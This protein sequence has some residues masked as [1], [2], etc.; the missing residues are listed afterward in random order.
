MAA[1]GPSV[2]HIALP[3]ILV[4]IERG[5]L[6]LADSC[7]RSAHDEISTE[8]FNR[9]VVRGHRTTLSSF[10][11]HIVDTSRDNGGL[12]NS[13]V[14][15]SEG[16]RN[17][18]V[19]MQCG[20]IVQTE[21][22]VARNGNRARGRIHRDSHRSRSLGGDTT[23]NADSLSGEGVITSF[24]EVDGKDIL[25]LTRNLNTVLIP[26]ITGNL[27]INRSSESNLLTLADGID[28]SRNIEGGGQLV[29]DN[30]NL[31][32]SSA[33][34]SS[35]V[36][37]GN[38]S[39]HMISSRA[40]GLD[41]NRGSRAV[42]SLSIPLISHIALPTILIDIQRGVFA[43]ADAGSGS[44]HKEVGTEGLNREGFRG[45]LTTK[46]LN[47][48]RVS[49]GRN[50][51]SIL[52]RTS[53]PSDVARNVA[54]N[55]Q[56][57]AVVLAN[58]IVTADRN[59]SRCRHDR[60]RS[61]SR[62]QGDTTGD[63]ESHNSRVA[64]NRDVVVSGE[65]VLAEGSASDTDDFLTVSVPS[66]DSAIGRSAMS[67]DRSGDRNLSAIANSVI[68]DENSRDLRN[69]VHRDGDFVIVIT[70]GVGLVNNNTVSGRDVRIHSVGRHGGT[71]DEV[72][73]LN[74]IGFINVGVILIVTNSGGHIVLSNLIPL[75]GKIVHVVVLQVGSQS[76]LAIGADQSLGSGDSH[77]RLRIDVHIELVRHGSASSRDVV[78]LNIDREDV[79][80]VA[81][82][83]VFSI[84][85]AVAKTVGIIV[86]DLTRLIPSVVEVTDGESGGIDI[87]NQEHRVSLTD[88]L[89]ASDHNNRIRIHIDGSR[90]GGLE[91]RGTTGLRESHNSSVSVVLDIIVNRG[92]IVKDGSGSSIRHHD[93][94]AIPSVDSTIGRHTVSVNRG[95][96]SNLST[97]TDIDVGNR[98][99]G[100]NR[101]RIHRDGERDRLS[102]TTRSELVDLDIVFM[103]TNSRNFSVSQRSSTRDILAITIPLEGEL[104]SIPIVE[105]QSHGDVTTNTDVGL[106]NGGVNDR[107]GIDV[108]LSLAGSRAC[109]VI[110]NLDRE[111]VRIISI[112]LV[113]RNLIVGNNRV[114]TSSQSSIIFHPIEGHVRTNIGGIHIGS[115]RNVVAFLN[116]DDRIGHENH[117]RIRV[118]RD[119]LESII[120][121]G[122]TTRSSLSDRHCIVISSRLTIQSADNFAVSRS[123]STLNNLTVTI[124]SEDLTAGDTASDR[125]RQINLITVT[126]SVLSSSVVQNN[127][128]IVIHDNSNSIGSGVTER[129]QLIDLNRVLMDTRSRNNRV[130]QL[131]GISNSCVAIVPTIGQLTSIPVSEVSREGNLTTVTN[132]SIGSSNGHNRLSVD[133]DKSASLGDASVVVDELD[134]EAVRIVSVILM[135][136][137]R[138]SLRDGDNIVVLHPLIGNRSKNL[139][140]DIGEQR[141][142]VA[143][144]VTNDRIGDKF[145]NRIRVDR[146]VIKLIINQRL[147][148][149][150]TLFHRNSIVVKGGFAINSDRIVSKDALVE[151]LNDLTI[152]V[153]SVNFTAFN[154]TIDNASHNSN[155]LTLT[156]SGLI[157]SD[158]HSLNNRNRVHINTDGVVSNAILSVE[159]H[160]MRNLN[161]VVG[162][163]ENRLKGLNLVGGTGEDMRVVHFILIPLVGQHR[164]IVVIEVGAQ[165]NITAFANLSSV[166]RDVGVRSLINIHIERIGKGGTTIAIGHQDSEDVG[167]LIGGHPRLAIV[168][169]ETR[170]IGS[171]L[172]ALIPSISSIEVNNT[173]NPSSKND[174]LNART[175]VTNVRVTVNRNDRVAF[176]MNRVRSNGNRLTTRNVINDIGF[177]SVI[178]RITIIDVGLCAELRTMDGLELHAI[179]LP[180]IV[181]IIVD[182]F[183]TIR[184]NHVS[185]NIQLG[186]FANIIGNEVNVVIDSNNTGNLIG[187]DDRHRHRITVSITTGGRLLNTDSVHN[188]TGDTVKERT[189]DMV[190]NTGGTVINVVPSHTI[191]TVLPLSN[192]VIHIPVAKVSCSGNLTLS[193]NFS[194]VNRGNNN[195]IFTHIDIVRFALHA[196]AFRSGH[197]K[198]KDIR[199]I[200][201]R[202]RGRDESIITRSH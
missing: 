129:S 63:R 28:I 43:A 148:T 197:D 77:N 196:A 202:K 112:G 139:G 192:Q 76:N 37:G 5:V 23:L 109:V 38:Y 3:T 179:Q 90:S 47:R 107:V 16:T 190:Q 158:E 69:R 117:N 162:S 54:V 87:R 39:R 167:V 134:A 100:D 155:G 121:V 173:I 161:N 46:S 146:N 78:T 154:T 131:R 188:I 94:I 65:D 120:D 12:A 1:G 149:R 104:I 105:I 96:N 200:L 62:H 25:V 141:D 124:P 125:G 58:H 143:S 153:P 2:G 36:R 30:G 103:F 82:I 29:D 75:I 183:I 64:V 66:I 198:S 201:C 142:V 32:L 89:I 14:A 163:T 80:F 71:G 42:A 133:I 150:S 102:L 55:S 7:S 130:A 123:G 18:G 132:V 26:D 166:S 48:N 168:V 31:T 169:I 93:T 67:V 6:A 27:R 98:N 144:G 189:R 92:R 194:V 172:T 135:E 15:P 184:T 79:G 176:H 13:T 185:G 193:A 177:V 119:G 178:N 81:R 127:C 137:N 35:T 34:T 17:I 165:R 116:T 84:E 122:L 126:N 85:L 114:R 61:R 195:G 182:I 22:V 51:N 59:S 9:E 180:H 52:M 140:L 99:I 72:T 56:D 191:K 44:A 60:H 73:I 88:V 115:Q 68:A 110:H 97:V 4:N 40:V 113:E 171:V 41:I 24:I 128:R 10:D 174:V 49:T 138:I 95:G 170:R 136:G 19:S 151:A 83:E 199:I 70:S 45:H 108:N 152:A 156:N 111:V 101:I 33:S 157:R 106:G 181:K 145:H 74:R 11:G 164:I 187:N 8:G 20:G 50:H 118:D 175:I 53:A 86:S 160:K 159:V 57:C 91:Q 21:D 147:T 186:A